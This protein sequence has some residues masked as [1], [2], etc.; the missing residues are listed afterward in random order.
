MGHAPTE[1]DLA[2]LEER[3]A[4][5]EPLPTPLPSAFVDA[6]NGLIRDGYIENAS[7]ANSAYRSLLNFFQKS[8]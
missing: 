6:I 2:Y 1:N 3:F 4:F 5:E 7:R 8:S